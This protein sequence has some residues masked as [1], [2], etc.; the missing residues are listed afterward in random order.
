MDL[1]QTY[2][3]AP[4]AAAASERG[5]L[6][7]AQACD[8]IGGASRLAAVKDFVETA[9]L[10]AVNPKIHAQETLK[11][12]AP[13]LLREDNE[14]PGAKVAVYT[15]GKSGWLAAGANAQPLSGPQAKQVNG[16]AFRSYIGLLLSGRDASRSLKAMGDSTVEI[17]DADGNVARLLLDQASHRPM[18]VA[19]YAVSVTGAP[20]EVREA[21]SGFREVSGIQVPFKIVLTQNG[22]AY[23]EIAVREFRINTGLKAED[24]EKRP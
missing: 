12:I 17:S 2:A 3:A 6:L 5:K 24:L 13:G 14:Y 23:A 20:P 21:W 11:W 19:Y 10:D 4:S 22:A 9:V 16:D 7:L 1:P 15:D 18:G 8:T